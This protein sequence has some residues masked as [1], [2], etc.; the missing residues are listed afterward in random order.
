MVAEKEEV[1]ISK[2]VVESKTVMQEAAQ[3]ST[4]SLSE[5]SFQSHMNFVNVLIDKM[6]NPKKT[7]HNLRPDEVAILKAEFAMSAKWSTAKIKAL[8]ERLCWPKCRV[9]KW[10][11]DQRR[12]EQRRFSGSASSSST[13]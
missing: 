6:N 3:A 7:R 1:D 11:Y 8:A 12:K 13:D 5:H 4:D 10:N 2:V 9:Y